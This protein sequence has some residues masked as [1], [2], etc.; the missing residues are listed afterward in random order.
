MAQSYTS[1]AAV[2]TRLSITDTTDD[3]L[4]TTITA[5]VNEWLE[6]KIGFPVGPITSEE[7]LFDGAAVKNDGYCL[8]IYPWGVRAVTAVRTATETDGSYTTRT[9]SDVVIR[10]HSHERETGWPGMELWV[11]D[12]ASWQFPTY[13][14]DVIG[15]TATWG[16]AAI[17]ETLVAIATRLA[18]ALYRGR[19]YGS[20]QTYAVGQDDVAAVAAEELSAS[21]WRTIFKYQNLNGLFEE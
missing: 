6:E 13:G 21:D 16:W 20:G 19:G 9:A 3:A 17:P 8:P 5:Q 2:K 18:V 7:R 1:N 11:K 14:M 15:I 4:F 12:N 10:P